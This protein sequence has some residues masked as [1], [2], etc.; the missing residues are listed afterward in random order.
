MKTKLSTAIVI[1]KHGFILMMLRDN[2]PGIMNPGV[3]SFVGGHIEDGES[4]IEALVREVFEETGLK[5]REDDCEKIAIL[6]EPTR[7]RNIFVVKGDWND[8]DITRGEGQ[9]M[10]F[11]SQKELVDLPVAPHV[12]KIVDLIRR[13]LLI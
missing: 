6:D 8:E 7:E 1:N 9:D 12:F 13:S 11:V 5:I 4:P 2:K 3:W 10:R